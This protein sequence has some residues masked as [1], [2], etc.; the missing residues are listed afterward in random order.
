MDEFFKQLMK[1]KFLRVADLR[2]NAAAASEA[3]DISVCSVQVANDS[4]NNKAIPHIVGIA[5]NSTVPPVVRRSNRLM[6]KPTLSIQQSQ[7]ARKLRNPCK[8]CATV[9][10]FSAG[11][12]KQEQE[13]S[14]KSVP[15]EDPIPTVRQSERLRNQTQPDKQQPEPEEQSQVPPKRKRGK[16]EQRTNILNPS[17]IDEVCDTRSYNHTK[18]RLIFRNS[19][20]G[21]TGVPC[22]ESHCSKCTLGRGRTV[23]RPIRAGQ[24]FKKADQRNI[25]NKT[26]RLRQKPVRQLCQNCGIGITNK[27][28]SIHNPS[29]QTIV[30]SQCVCTEIHGRLFKLYDLAPDDIRPAQI[31]RRRQMQRKR[32]VIR[33]KLGSNRQL[34]KNKKKPDGKRVRPRIYPKRRK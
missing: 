18:A 20:Y 26:K 22:T 34:R 23:R 31:N 11:G 19:R 13:K 30:A 5:G 7:S 27:L 1:G 24:Q 32:Q 2:R 12:S 3:D 15:S 14:Q 17:V 9:D 33:R 4:R 21:C 29:N 8:G 25:K 6:K 10:D 16:K 28:R